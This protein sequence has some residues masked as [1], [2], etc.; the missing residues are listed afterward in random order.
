[1]AA[2]TSEITTSTT[3]KV[4]LDR[5]EFSATVR[6]GG[7]Q[8]HCHVSSDEWRSYASLRLAP[9]EARTIGRLLLALA[10]QLEGG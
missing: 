1:M 7:E 8:L 6:L 2:I 5:G 9:D 4:A 3:H 10:D